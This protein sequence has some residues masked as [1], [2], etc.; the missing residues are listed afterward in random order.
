MSFIERLRREHVRVE[1]YGEP[2]YWDERYENY[3][4]EH[5][6]NFSFDWY[7]EPKRIAPVLE[8]HIGTESDR[9]RKI[10][11]LGCGNSKLSEVRVG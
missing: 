4:R 9:G 1:P 7:V 10:L 5:G 2:T 11:V 8:M 6:Q 3:R